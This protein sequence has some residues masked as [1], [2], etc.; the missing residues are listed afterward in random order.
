MLGDA[1]SLI[2]LKLLLYSFKMMM[3]LKINFHKSCVYN[4]CRSEEMGTRAASILNC[5]FGALPFTYL[6]LPIKAA[7]LIRE[8]W[9]PLMDRLEKRFA[10]WK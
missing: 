2:T 8:D 4:L 9:K 7:T 3:G 5:H 10:T 6:G 1:K